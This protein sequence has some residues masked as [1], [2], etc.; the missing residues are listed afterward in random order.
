MQK[1][2]GDGAA[3]WRTWLKRGT[4]YTATSCLWQS[5]HYNAAY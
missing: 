5:T 2:V 1:I 4:Q 3:I